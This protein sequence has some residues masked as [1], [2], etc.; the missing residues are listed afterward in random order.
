MI[1]D[2]LILIKNQ[3]KHKYVATIAPS[4]AFVI[5]KVCAKINFEKDILILECGPGTGVITKALLKKLSR[6]SRLIAIEKNPDFVYH[7]RQIEDSRLTIVE[8]DVR[9]V[10]GIISGVTE[11]KPDYIVS[12]IPFSFLEEVERPVLVRI[13]HSLLKESGGIILYQASPLMKKYLMKYF[14]HVR[15]EFEVRNIPPLFIMSASK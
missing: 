12:G 3:L 9:D 15:T 11:D 4:S 10:E 2:S 6:N 1:R 8:G 13:F 14:K 5:K 7:L